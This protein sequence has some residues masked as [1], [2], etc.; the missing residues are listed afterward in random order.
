MDCV[1]NNALVGYCNLHH[2]LSKPRYPHKRIP[3]HL[4][5]DAFDH[6]HRFNGRRGF[7]YMERF[8]Q[9]LP[10]GNKDMRC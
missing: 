1:Y 4:E 6:A 9:K 3:K 2:A 8:L 5:I 10:E 7:D